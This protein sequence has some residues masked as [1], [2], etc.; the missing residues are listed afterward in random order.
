M[1][2]VENALADPALRD[3]ALVEVVDPADGTVLRSL[4]YGQADEVR[5]R[6]AGRLRR[7]VQAGARVGLVA[8]NTPEWVVADLAL[9][10]ADLVEV[11]VPLAF[12][13]EQAG[14]LLT[15]TDVCLVDEQGAVRLAEWGFGAGRIVLRIDDEGSPDV[16]TAPVAASHPAPA[17]DVVKIIH[18]SGTTGAPKG[19]MIRR[20]GIEALLE[21]LA[22][23]LPD[24]GLR[25]YVSLV[26]F[27]LLIEQ[28]AGLYLPASTGGT[29]VLLPPDAALLGTAGSRVEDAL[30][31]LGALHPT[32]AV[33]PPAVVSALAKA[34]ADAAGDPVRA[35]FG[36]DVP[37]LLMAGGAPVDAKALDALAAVGIEVLEGYGLS[38]NSSVVAWNR[39]GEAVSGTVGRPLAHCE[40]RIGPDD[41]LLVRSTSL[42]AG[43]T[44]EDPTSRPVD[45]DGWLHTGDRAS[46]DADGRLRILGRLKNMI[47]TGFGRN[48]S[49]EWVE[50]RLRSCPSVRES[51]VFGDGL[52]HLVALV[53]TD[54][55]VPADAVRAEVAEYCARSL[56]ETD[57]PE[58]VL[59]LEDGR[60]L[61][62]RYFTVTGRPRREL[63]YAEQVEPY[64]SSPAL[65]SDH[66]QGVPAQMSTTT[67]SLVNRTRL[68]AGTGVVLTPNGSEVTL[69][70]VAP[71]LLDQL[72]EA[73]HLLLRGFGP[74]LADFNDLVRKASGKVTLDP[75]R[76]F[77]GDIAQLVDSGTDAIGLH[78]ENGATPYPPDLL[79][80]HCVTAA[81]SGS[82]TTVCDGRRVWERLD[83]PTRRLFF[84]NPI[85]F[86]R[87]VSEEQWRQ[88]T[89][90]SLGDGR[91]PSE[92]TLDDLRHLAGLGHATITPL[93]DG[94]VHYRFETRAARP[95]R[96]SEEPVWANSLFGPSYNYEAPQIRFA[97]GRDIPQD[98]L[99]E[100]ARITEEV[101]EEIAWQDGDVVLI[102]NSRVMHGRRAITDSR[103]MIVNA[104]SFAAV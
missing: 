98:V 72:R 49:P 63:L 4:S 104:Q 32:A 89:A 70:D 85:V 67:A 99:D 14:S 29:L 73:G 69:L 40:V 80:F 60:S 97:D 36:Q 6:L 88:F 78:I 90:F 53:L 25:R 18:T 48:I 100:L 102:D 43:Y 39:P 55:T 19:V 62:E 12:S 1:R 46:I 9:L 27:S 84:D 64:L 28:V 38:E 31:W 79:W 59:V 101:T 71:I 8:G 3:L 57:R 50:G 82:Q 96:W 44:V 83:E 68:G 41:E 51:V 75:A 15:G 13:A 87:S 77:H 33:L 56:A 86:A 47:I 30:R 2:T 45:E 16:V 17:A 42:F 93:A 22:A 24:G 21:S 95:S 91:R 81:R 61:R 66:Q 58:R 23:M 65:S 7:H 34:A 26:P 11:P 74:S 94:A 5:R 52:E 20:A 54:G 103:R 76:Q 92:V 10:T 37:P 35:L